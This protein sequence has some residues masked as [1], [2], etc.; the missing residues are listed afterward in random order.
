M[1]S[2]VLS[3]VG[4]QDPYSKN[5]DEG[6]LVS[7]VKYLCEQQDSIKRI[8]L[9]YTEGTQQN[10]IDTRDWLLSEV[11]TLTED[12]IALLPVSH[13]FS[14]DPINQLLAVQ[15]A[16]LAI[17]QAQAYK[18]EQDTLVF[19]GSSGTPAMKACWSILQASGYAAESQVWQVRDP[20]KMQSG[21]A[22][23]FRNDVNVL[24]NEFDLKVIRQ[25]V[26]DYNYSGA[27]MTFNASSLLDETITALLRYGYYRI[28][29]DFNRAFSVLNAVS[30]SV[31]SQWMQDIALLRQKDPRALLK[32]GYFNALTRLKNQKYA[33]FLVSL[34]GLQESTLKFL[35]TKK[36]GLSVSSKASERE[37]SWATLRQAEQGRLY[38]HLQR[39]I[40]PRGGALRLDESISRYVL[41]AIVDYFP[42]FSPIAQPFKELNEYCDR[43][44]EYVHEFIGISEIEDEARVL[45]NLRKIM[46][47]VVGVSEENPF[48]RLNQEICN[49]LDRTLMQG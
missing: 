31:N 8:L 12:A 4:S 38:Q 21:Q 35:V 17:E 41:I 36:I 39:Y 34:F 43:R 18:I 37:Q 20:Q 23:V 6:S 47:Q 44:N 15:E 11:R 45:G 32:E 5:H 27:L 29:L 40:L 24:K 2:I 42:Q 3:F 49:L 22:R 16:R 46:K 14:H 25:Q 30:N 1:A 33:D 26:Q 10:A 13:A 19:N 7:L 9:L 48:D 28:S